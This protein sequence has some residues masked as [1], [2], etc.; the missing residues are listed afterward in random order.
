M[1]RVLAN[2]SFIRS[3]VAARAGRLLPALALLCALQAPTAGAEQPLR[4]AVAAN[5]RSAAEQLGEQ[6]STA[7]GAELIISTASTGILV[8]QLRRGAPFDLLL[9]ADRE[10]PEA[11]VADG[12]AHTTAHCYAVGS[13]VLLGRDISD[14]SLASLKAALADPGKSLAIANPRSAPYGAAAQTVLEREEFAAAKD[15]RIVMGNNVQQAL[16]F[17]SSGATDLAL[18]ARSVSPSAGIA[19]PGEWH[20]PIEQFAVISA[21]S[22]QRSLAA[23]FLT[24]ITSAKAA[25]ALQDLGYQTCS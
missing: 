8:A 5:F 3:A 16:Q 10:R 18:V 22:S 12:T 15:R 23:D 21:R 24:F 7:T 1:S 11:L 14:E 17:Y 25:P 6:F 20:A 4:V 13:L 9:A 2:R 19:V